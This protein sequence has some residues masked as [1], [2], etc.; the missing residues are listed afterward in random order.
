MTS[1]RPT[2]GCRSPSAPRRPRSTRWTSKRNVTGTSFVEVA[3]GLAAAGMDVRGDYAID[4]GQNIILWG[5]VSEQFVD[6]I[7]GVPATGEVHLAPTSLL[8]YMIF[9]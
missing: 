6:V 2:R 1:T 7:R 3:R 8:V 9:G 5:G 4:I